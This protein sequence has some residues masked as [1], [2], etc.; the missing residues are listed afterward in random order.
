MRQVT[1]KSIQVQ[2]DPPA[3]TTPG[4]ESAV[5]RHPKI[6]NDPDTSD[7]R[8]RMTT[9]YIGFGISWIFMVFHGILMYFA[10]GGVLQTILNKP[11]SMLMILELWMVSDDLK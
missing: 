7:S 9:Y 4:L 8:R 11:V 10:H 6:Q 3:Q 5:P 1:Q 2:H